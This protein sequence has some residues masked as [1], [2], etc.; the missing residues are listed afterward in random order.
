[1]IHRPTP[2]ATV[3]QNRRWHPAQ[4]RRRRAEIAQT[5]IGGTMSPIVAEERQQHRVAAERPA[6]GGVRQDIT[7]ADER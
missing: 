5:A 4:R 6:A 3:S 2:I 1:M 7:E